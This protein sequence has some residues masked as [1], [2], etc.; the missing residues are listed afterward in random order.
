MELTIEQV[1]A[2]RGGAH[3]PLVPPEVGEECVVLR[4]DA[5]EKIA[6][7]LYDDSDADPRRF[8][9]LAGAIMAEDDADDPALESYQKY[10]L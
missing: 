8:Y 9:P 3:V 7:P 6:H 4:R 1:Q 10:K 5:Y 2:I